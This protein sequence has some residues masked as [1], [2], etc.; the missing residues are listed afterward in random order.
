MSGLGG[1]KWENISL[2]PNAPHATTTVPVH[3]VFTTHD[4]LL[5]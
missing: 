5:P 2:T 3:S 4:G 1:K